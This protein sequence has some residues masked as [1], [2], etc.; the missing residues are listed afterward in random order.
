MDHA[1]GHESNPFVE[2][3]TAG[4][5]RR[6]AQ[7]GTAAQRFPLRD[8]S[9]AIHR[10]LI[11]ERRSTRP[12]PCALQDALNLA[13]GGG[14]RHSDMRPVVRATVL[15]LTAENFENLGRVGRHCAAQNAASLLL[16]GGWRGDGGPAARSEFEPDVCRASVNAPTSTQRFDDGEPMAAEVAGA[17]F[18][19]VSLEALACIDD[20]ALN[21][22]IVRAKSE[23]D[24]T[25]TVNDCVRY[26]F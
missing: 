7:Q 5:L 16:S 10:P 19:H 4:S 11:R 22:S 2:G 1:Q 25:A 12:R 20:L 21:V 8:R 24:P 6:S 18:A 13:G 26:K 14:G 3:L 9:E 15:S 23:G 17:S